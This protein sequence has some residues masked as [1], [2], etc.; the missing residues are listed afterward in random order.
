MKNP[1]PAGTFPFP[2]ELISPLS[3]T[4]LPSCLLGSFLYSPNFNLQFLSSHCLYW[5][6]ICPY[7]QWRFLL[8]TKPLQ[9]PVKTNTI[10]LNHCIPLTIRQLKH[11]ILPKNTLWNVRAI[12]SKGVCKRESKDNGCDDEQMRLK[13]N[14]SRFFYQ[15]TNEPCFSYRSWGWNLG[16]GSVWSVATR[17]CILKVEGV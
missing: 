4:L 8:H 12:F 15:T 11:P 13:R 6:S 5:F 9:P 3:T 7:Y 16:F 10:E 14:F 2:A 17:Y 1:Y